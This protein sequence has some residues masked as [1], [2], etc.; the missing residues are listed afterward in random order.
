MRLVRPRRAWPGK[1]KRVNKKL[2]LGKSLRPWQFTG[3][4]WRKTVLIGLIKGLGNRDWP[5]TPK[6]CG[7]RDVLSLR[8]YWPSI[9]LLSPGVLFTFLL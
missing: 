2:N 7:F 8:D 4:V 5:K 6:T 1:E 9:S 3:V